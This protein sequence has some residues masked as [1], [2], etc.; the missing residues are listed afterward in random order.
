MSEGKEILLINRDRE[1]LEAM[2]DF[3]RKSGYIVHTAQEMQ[4]AL[5]ALTFYSVRLILC[6]NVL[7]DITGYDFLRFLKND[8]LR[9]SIPFVFFVPIN[10]QG[11]AFKAFELG[12]DDFWVYPMEVD[13]LVN[14]I[15]EIM[16][17]HYHQESETTEEGFNIPG[18][19]FSPAREITFS[20]RRQS[21]RKQ[22][23]PNFKVYLSRDEMLW[24][25]GK[26]KNFSLDGILV[27]TPLLGKPGVSILVKFTLP[28][29]TF[30][31][32]GE[33]KHVAFDDFQQ[34]VGI[35]I[36][37]ASASNWGVVYKYFN[38]LISSASHFP[39]TQ[40]FG[41][42]L[43]CSDKKQIEK[44]ILLSPEVISELEE[45]FLL[46]QS[47]RKEEESYELRFYQSLIGKQL[48]NYKAVSFLGAG[49]MGGVFR[50]WDS[51]LER[52]V[53]LKVISYE[54]SSQETFREMFIK[55]ARIISQLDHPNIAHIYS[56]GD[57]DGILFFAMELIMGE[58]LADL[59]KKHGNLYT[60]R[61]LNYFLTV[62]QT[63]NFVWQK[64]IIHRDI[65]PANIVIN[66]KGVLKIVDFG[67]AQKIGLTPSSREGPEKIVGSPFYISPE[68]ISGGKVDHR[69]D[70]Y[71]L[72]ATFYHVFTGT[73]PFEGNNSKEI[74]LQ[75][76]NTNPR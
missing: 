25:P 55:E 35:G 26:I 69:S 66:N 16:E 27:L 21:K 23:F 5:L 29:E 56:I 44:T 48:G 8:P 3:L 33:I 73:P 4:E 50:G 28:Q 61:G 52:E 31:I 46:A 54:L 71:S 30:T 76:L 75:H 22:P 62:C 38:S 40:I 2:A 67:V 1:F 15:N 45:S 72:G 19:T 41:E 74:L 34:P 43:A 65:K 7:Q 17:L 60:I 47:S 70:I 37:F 18:I 32:R 42:Q 58:T 12:A 6:D 57:I 49:S 10:D 14:R 13:V 53:A 20:E 64:N 9:N 59:I 63:L 68:A 39:L 11:R 24:M 36:T 51:A